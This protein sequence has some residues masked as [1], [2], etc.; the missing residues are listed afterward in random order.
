MIPNDPSHLQK[1]FSKYICKNSKLKLPCLLPEPPKCPPLEHQT[2]RP[3]LHCHFPTLLRM[4]WCQAQKASNLPGFFNPCIGQPAVCFAVCVFLNKDQLRSDVGGIWRMMEATG[5][6]ASDPQSPL[7]QVADEI[8]WH[9]CHIA[10]PSQSRCL[11]MYF[12]RLPR[13]LPSSR[14]RWRDMVV[15]TP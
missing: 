2:P 5:E 7:H 4:A 8:C 13:T 15:M 12:A 6:R 1:T 14:L 11:E 3:H 10:S 9:D